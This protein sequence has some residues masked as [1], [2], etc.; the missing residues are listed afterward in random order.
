MERQV[1]RGVPWILPLVGHRNHVGVVQVFPLL[2]AA[3]ET[4]LRRRRCFRVAFQPT[5][6]DVMIELF[7]PE[8]ARESLAHNIARIE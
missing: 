5:L 3:V 1:P 6:D 7:R 4:F 8:H 2:I